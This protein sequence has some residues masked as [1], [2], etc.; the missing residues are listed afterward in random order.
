MSYFFYARYMGNVLFFCD[1]Y[2]VTLS[3]I[4]HENEYFKVTVVYF[5]YFHS[6]ISQSNE[7]HLVTERTRVQ[8]LE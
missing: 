4:T 3:N 8:L 7:G 6:V 2:K 5:A 1:E